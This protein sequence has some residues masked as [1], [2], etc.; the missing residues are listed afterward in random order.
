M[1]NVFGVG[2]MINTF[3]VGLGRSNNN[4]YVSNICILSSGLAI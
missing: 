3:G 4:K 1:H 2:T